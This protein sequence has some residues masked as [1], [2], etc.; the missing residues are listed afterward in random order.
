MDVDRFD[1]LARTVA[2]RDEEQARDRALFETLTRLV[3][4]KGTRRLALAGLLAMVLHG[5]GLQPTAAQCRGKEDKNKR[6]CR[7]R[8]RK[9]QAPGAGSSCGFGSQDKLF[10]VCTPFVPTPC[11]NGLGCTPTAGIFVDACQ[12]PCATDADCKQKFPNKALA[13][14][15]DALVCPFIPGGKCCVPR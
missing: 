9:E 13:C 10:G 8:E 14:R 7:R 1:G 6:Q 12:F 2:E 3:A 11:C 15:P 5:V 4:K